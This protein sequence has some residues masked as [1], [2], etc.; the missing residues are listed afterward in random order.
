[1]WL[2]RGLMSDDVTTSWRVLVDEA[3]RRL[4]RAGVE[5]AEVSARR[6]GE[7]AAGLEG[8]AFVLG[9][10][11]P[12]S[13]RAVARF[14]SMVGRRVGGEPLQYVLRRWGFRTLD[15]LVDPRVLIPRPET[16][17]VV[18]EALTELDRLAGAHLS[19]PERTAG[20]TPQRFRSGEI[21]VESTSNRRRRTIAADL[22]CGSGAIGLSIAAERD[23][24]D[25][26]CVDSSPDALAVTRANL[27]G[28]GMAG[29]HVAVLEGSWFDPL[30]PQLAGAIDLIVTNPPYVA[31]GDELPA[32]VANWEPI[33]ALVAGA[34][35]LE[36]I[37]QI[38]QQAPQ[39]L[40]P[41]GVLVSEIGDSHGP[42]AAGAA[43][44][45]G[46]ETVEIRPDLAGRDRTLVARQH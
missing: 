7:E 11:Q 46:F 45:A 10:D 14:D 19:A 35:G 3:A 1:V 30:P 34:T 12:T 26:W 8:V 23:Q 9:L 36:A 18:E 40:A 27:A 2:R 38:V 17:Q 31:T 25:V 41:G 4:R 5:S 13:E 6:I 29:T 15:L 28:L 32:E 22:G 20:A 44:R 39:W 37:E 24:V 42:A 43:S 16:E 21:S 33:A